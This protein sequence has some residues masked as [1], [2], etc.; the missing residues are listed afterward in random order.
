MAVTKIKVVLIKELQKLLD[1]DLDQFIWHLLNP[2]T[3]DITPILPAKLQ[4]ANR[5]D[6]VD[7]MASQYSTDAGNIAVQVLRCMEKNDLASKL[8]GK[9]QEGKE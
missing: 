6:V 2:M 3:E 4:K 1:E 8:E 9:L 7:C 5:R